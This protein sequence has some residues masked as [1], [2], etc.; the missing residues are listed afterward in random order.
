LGA[1]LGK[2]VGQAHERRVADRHAWQIAG[3]LSAPEKP[4][5]PAGFGWRTFTCHPEGTVEL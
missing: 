3:Q 1:Q 2:R 5:E 4:A